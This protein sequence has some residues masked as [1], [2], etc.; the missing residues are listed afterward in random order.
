M[1]KAPGFRAMKKNRGG[2]VFGVPSRAG[3]MGKVIDVMI[4]GTFECSDYDCIGCSCEEILPET[5]SRYTGKEDIRGE[6]IYE[7]DVLESEFTGERR[8]Y[9]VAF[10]KGAFGILSKAD[11]Q[12]HFVPFAVLPEE[13]TFE[14]VGNVIETPEL[15]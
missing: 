9:E 4:C 8:R 7:K 10:T 5:I 3:Y 12:K 1:K 15:F 2:W 11:R 6:S 14:I 13:V